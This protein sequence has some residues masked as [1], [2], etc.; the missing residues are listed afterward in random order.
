M[1]PLFPERAVRAAFFTAPL[2]LPGWVFA[3]QGAVATSEPN[4]TLAGLSAL[5]D[6]GN[7][8]DAAIAASFALAVTLPA[9]GNLGGGGFLLYR[10]AE[11]AAWFLDHREVA[12]TNAARGMY[13]DEK[14]IPIPLASRMGWKA[15]GVPG[16]VIGL[17]EAHRR[18]GSLKWKDL[19]AP[20]I[21][22]AEQGFSIS[23]RE[24]RGIARAANYFAADPFASEVFLTKDG[25]ALPVGALLRQPRLGAT[26]RKI[27]EDGEAA[28]REGPIVEGIVGASRL[29]GGIL[30][31][32]DFRDYQPVLR[33]VHAFAWK[34]LQ[35]L[36]ASPPSSGGIFLEQ[37]LTLLGDGVLQE[38]GPQDAKA[39]QLIAEVEAAA[40]RDR[41]RWLGDPAG[42]D[43]LLSD[44]TDS[45]Y[46]FDLR[47][48]LSPR[49]YTPPDVEL[50]GSPIESEETTHL[51][52][53]DGDGGAVALTTT[54]NSGYGAKVMAPGG[55]LMNNEMDD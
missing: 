32:K 21:E 11:G 49:R 34:G 6:G 51:S 1:G 30:S 35:V 53:V 8:V 3:A 33:P 18:W 10:D 14:G 2:C 40:F 37:T 28:F 25:K 24:H 42:F 13:L 19:L 47:G 5:K 45:D 7:A 31:L 26:L 52:T 20:A 29:D 41:N 27:A 38:W 54:L 16:T 9:A 55:F 4:A 44:L 36:A 39:I 17:A 46:L 22:L 43:F 50:A 15:A 12:P 23:E 48:R